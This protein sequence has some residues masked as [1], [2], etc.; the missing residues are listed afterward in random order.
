MSSCKILILCFSRVLSI[1]ARRTLRDLT[2]SYSYLLKA[3]FREVKAT[4]FLF[5]KLH[6][7][8]DA[9]FSIL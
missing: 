9:E 1:E 3:R 6:F 2:M 8:G 5:S 7:R 4:N